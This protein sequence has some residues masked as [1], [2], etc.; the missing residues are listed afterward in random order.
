M[1]EVTTVLISLLS[2]VFLVILLFWLYQDYRA[3]AF[4]QK[5]L[6]LRDNLFDE[7]RCGKIDFNDNSYKMLRDAINGFITFGHRLNL[8]EI[9]VFNIVL[10]KETSAGKTFSEK[11]QKNL[12]GYSHQQRKIIMRYYIKMNFYIIEHMF[13]S[14]FILLFTVVTPAVFLLLAK[15]HINRIVDYF[16]NPL[17]K[18]DTAALATGKIQAVET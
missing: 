6:K 7:A 13:L 17:D 10:K 16:K 18:L 1:N 8:I 9:L 11:L 2:I 15:A 12:D 3:N 5:M 4:R 14:S